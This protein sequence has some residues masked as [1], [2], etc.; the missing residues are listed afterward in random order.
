MARIKKP[1]TITAWSYSRWEVWAR[2]P[3]AAKCK[4]I[5]KIPEPP[6]PFMERGNTLHKKAE[7]YVLGNIRGLPKELKSFGQELKELKRMMAIPEEDLAVTRAWEPTT[8]DDWDNVW[9]RGKADATLDVD[10][11]STVI[12]Y[13]SGKIYEE[14][15]KDQGELMA[16]LKFCH[17]S[18]V[19]FIDV[20]F[21]YFDQEDVLD[22]HYERKDLP[23]LIKKWEKRVIPMM[24]DK[25]FKP[26]PSDDACLW[27]NFHHKKGGPCNEGV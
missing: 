22:W 5:D 14:K 2:C 6:N 9:C 23:A 10:D 18:K 26:T 19:Q 11:E 24:R 15:H 13:K 17:N 12:D 25:T 16:T 20:E 1:T 4:F 21:W 3:F 7:H 8:F 27:C